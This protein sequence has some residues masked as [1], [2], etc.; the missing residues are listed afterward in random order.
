MLLLMAFSQLRFSFAGKKVLDFKDKL[1]DLE[2]YAFRVSREYEDEKTFFEIFNSLLEQDNANQLE[3]ILIG[4][5][6]DELFDENSA[7]VVEALVAAKDK[8]SNLKGIF[9]G[10]ITYEQCEVSWLHQCDVAPL[11]HAYPKLEYF[12]VRGS[13]DLVFGHLEHTGLK[14]LTVQS[15][16]LDVQI[17]RDI[18]GSEF[19]N[20]EH[21]DLYLGTDGYGANTAVDDLAPLFRGEIFP[22]LN[23][24]GLR[25]SDLSDAIAGAIANSP[26]LERIKTLDLSLGTLSDEGA[27]ALVASEKLSNLEKLDIHYHYV[28]EAVVGELRSH[29]RKHK[30]KLDAAEPQDPEDDWRA[31]QTGE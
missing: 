5:W 3:A 17:V 29:L 25:N 13:N 23:R 10:D 12:G 22:N 28:S 30:V 18:L 20:L 14:Q 2:K 11:F 31:P 15:G 8:L 1:F 4:A 27:K 6:S 24:L 9:L 7:P 19:P 16:G 26:I 21:L